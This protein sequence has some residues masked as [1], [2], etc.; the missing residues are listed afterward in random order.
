MDKKRIVALQEILQR[1]Q[2]DGALYGVSGNM[3]YLLDDPAFTFQRTPQTGGGDATPQAFFNNKTDAVLYVPALGAPLLIAT[4]SRQDSFKHTE[5][6]KIFCFYDRLHRHLHPYLTGNRIA[7]GLACQTHLR[8]M[9]AEIDST[10]E[11]VA[12]EAF[13]ESLRAI[14]DDQEI[15][16]LRELAKLT[17]YAMGEVTKQLKAGISQYEIGDLIASIG[18]ERGASE[19]PFFPN[20]LFTKTGHPTAQV[21]GSYNKTWPLEENTAIAFDFGYVMNGYCSD[22]GRSFYYGKA[23][24]RIKNAY[25]ALQAA[26]VQVIETIKPGDP[27]NTY[28]PILLTE[29]GKH[30][31]AEDLYK[32]NDLVTMGHQIGINV[33]E[34][35]W[36]N[37]GIEETFKPGMVMCIEPKIW[38]PGECYIR[39]EDMILITENGA[40]S[41]T[42]YSRSHFEL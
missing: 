22:F 12:G 40:E 7:V 29:L 18:R 41:L 28:L 4:H 9:I 30:G 15:K 8:E 10:I 31:F 26:Q 35:P 21:R 25:V 42:T 24:D 5:I 16:L 23:S 33:H 20:A 13:V 6:K 32:H 19:L 3:Y 39:V 1:E 38:L 11:T 2:L 14:K 34:H 36:L 17:D 37:T 27:I